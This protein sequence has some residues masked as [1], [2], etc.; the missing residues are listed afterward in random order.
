MHAIATFTVASALALNALW[1]CKSNRK[2]KADDSR[3]T[4]A[5]SAIEPS[6]PV[7]HLAPGELHAGR[8]LAFGFP[9]PIGMSVERAFPDAIHLIGDVDVQGLVRYVRANARTSNLELRGNRMIFENVRIPAIGELRRFR[10]ELSGGGRPTRLLI[11]DVT[12]NAPPS[13]PTLSDEERWRRAGMKPNGDPLD[14]T[15]LR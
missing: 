10:V 8:E 14:V 5:L 12:P 2:S 4:T 1:G 7:D 9:I 11:K 13:E 15:Q 6:P 3:P